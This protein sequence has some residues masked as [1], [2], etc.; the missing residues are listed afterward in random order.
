MV[1][2]SALEGHI[3][4]YFPESNSRESLID[5]LYYVR[6]ETDDLDVV[7]ITD[8]L[9]KKLKSLTDF[10]FQSLVFDRLF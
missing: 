9:I 2:F 3:I 6:T 4:S 8:S 7:I 10:E 1:E 5:A